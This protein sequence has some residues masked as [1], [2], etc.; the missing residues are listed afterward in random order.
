MGKQ[1]NSVYVGRSIFDA[2]FRCT[3]LNVED[4]RSWRAG[5]RSRHRRRSLLRDDV[6][7]SLA[8]RYRSVAEGGRGSKVSELKRWCARGASGNRKRRR[9]ISQDGFQARRRQH[10]R[11]SHGQVEPREQTAVEPV[12]LEHVR[13]VVAVDRDAPPVVQ[14]KLRVVRQDFGRTRARVL[15]LDATVGLEGRRIEREG[16]VVV[17]VVLRTILASWSSGFAKRKGTGSLTFPCC[18]MTTAVEHCG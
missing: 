1:R 9:G 10:G 3:R 18:Q 12:Q 6:S 4:G 15:H 13:G 7:C 17:E 16:S 14:F 2:V 5:Y 8:S 11:R